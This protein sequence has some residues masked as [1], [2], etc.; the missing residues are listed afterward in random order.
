MITNIDS[1]LKPFYINCIIF[2]ISIISLKAN[3]ETKIIAKKGDTLFSISEQYGVPLK[4]LMYK[5]SFN[6]ASKILE[7]EVVV[8][9]L[10]KNNKGKDKKYIIYKVIEGDTLFK[11]A[12]KNN[13]KLVDLISI[14]N[15]NKDSYL[16]VDQILRI[17]NIA[18]YGKL[19]DSENIKLSSKKVFYHQTSKIENLSTIAKIHKISIEE[20]STLNKLNNPIKI[21]PNIK[22]QLRKNKTPKWLKYGPIIINWSD[23]TF[24][25]GNYIAAA[26]TKKNTNFHMAISCKKRALN[27]TLNNSY[28]TNWYFPKTYFEFELINEFCDE[29]F[30]F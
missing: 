16:K 26:R 3:A 7:G 13:V 24:Y 20:I 27:N 1:N 15:L 25:N 4:E 2:I 23:W 22:L 10:E 12:N 18:I 17:P 9:P 14:N 19:I 29:S 11:I 6:D 30:K 28:W 5:N 21:N 8:I